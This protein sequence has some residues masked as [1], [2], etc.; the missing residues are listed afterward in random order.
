MREANISPEVVVT[1]IFGILQLIM[2]ATALWQQ[3]YL[4][5]ENCETPNLGNSNVVLM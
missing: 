3:H 2:A 1:I 5:W 4:R